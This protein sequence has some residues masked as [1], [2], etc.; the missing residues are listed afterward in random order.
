MTVRRPT[1]GLGIFGTLVCL[2][3]GLGIAPAASAAPA[4]TAEATPPLGGSLVIDVTQDPGTLNPFQDGGIE[5]NYVSSD[6]RDRL[7]D[8][9]AEGQ[10]APALATS[11]YQPNPST[12]IFNLRHGVRFSNG[13]PSAPPMSSTPLRNCWGKTANSLA[14]GRISRAPRC[15]G[16]TKSS[17]R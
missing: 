17:S 13:P 5:G 11:W 10:P 7:V 6:I 2:T 1:R 14:T 8:P 12:Y 3:A 16:R 15:S 9:N 4:R